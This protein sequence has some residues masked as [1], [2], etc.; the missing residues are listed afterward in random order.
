MCSR[1]EH[2]DISVG[3]SSSVG[4]I[5]SQIEELTSD[6]PKYEEFF[7]HKFSP[8]VY[9]IAGSPGSLTWDYAG[10]RLQETSSLMELF[11]VK[12]LDS[13]MVELKHLHL[14]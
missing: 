4:K 10:K 13:L 1:Y 14:F 9:D 5:L 2:E 3:V 12:F 8:Q 6:A 7:K 11:V